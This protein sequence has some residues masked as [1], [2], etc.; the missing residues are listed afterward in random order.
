MAMALINR[1]SRLF[2]ADFHAVLDRI[3][4]PE[5]LLRQAIRDM[6]DQL[7]ES[8][9]QGK[10]RA[11]EQQMLG[12]RIAELGS[13]LDETDTELDLCFESG[14][15]ELARGLVRKKLEFQRLLQKAQANETGNAEYL[16][17][18]RKQIDENRA[19]LESL[20][21]KADVFARCEPAR[22]NAGYEDGR[23]S[24]RDLA[25]S[26]TDIEVALLRERS[27]RRAS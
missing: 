21:Q 27:A 4:E 20:K 12:K 18:L 11:H 2:K 16:A 3:E 10:V 23:W 24:T 13:K 6:D 25:I 14:K 8:E 7:A 1:I 15:D 22:A 9:Q 17:D 19:A 5:Q 26:D